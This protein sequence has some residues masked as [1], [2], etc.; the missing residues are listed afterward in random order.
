MLSIR[1]L[2]I[3]QVWSSIGQLHLI[4]DNGDP[5]QDCRIDRFIRL[6][7]MAINRCTFLVLKTQKGVEQL[8]EPTDKRWQKTTDK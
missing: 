7:G 3:R 8:V 1:L 5:V 4:S 6:V 2:P